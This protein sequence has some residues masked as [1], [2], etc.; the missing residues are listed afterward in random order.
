MRHKPSFEHAPL[1][2]SDS[3]QQHLPMSK[4]LRMTIGWELWQGTRDYS[5]LNK[6]IYYRIPYPAEERPSSQ[7][8]LD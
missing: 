3:L 8:G 5:I 4:G 2:E 6:T 1:T 7:F